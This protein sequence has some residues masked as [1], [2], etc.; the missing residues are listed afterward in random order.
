MNSIIFQLLAGLMLL[1]IPLTVFYKNDR[2]LLYRLLT[3]TGCWAIAMLVL[4]VVFNFV[5]QSAVWW[6]DV[7]LLLLLEVI[8]TMVCCRK[9]WLVVPILIGVLPVTFIV[10][11]LVMGI[12]GQN[13]FGN[14]WFWVPVMALLHG[15]ALR[16]S[17][18]GLL[19]YAFNRKVHASMFEYL[20]G[21]GATQTEALRPFLV[22]AMSKALNPLLT[23]MRDTGLVAVPAI[24]CVLMLSGMPPIQAGI[25]AVAATIGMVCCSVLS[26]LLS[27]MVYEW[28]RR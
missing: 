15:E 12:M 3:T 8:V 26:I 1:A 5:F 22:R 10:G 27:V 13:P 9:K 4:V 6:L 14:I 16:A 21:N 20:Q 18:S 17:R 11:L 2:R 25:F 19:T 7:L 28:L 24:L 23:K